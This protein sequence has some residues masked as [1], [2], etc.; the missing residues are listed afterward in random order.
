MRVRE[1]TGGDRSPH[2]AELEDMGGEAEKDFHSAVVSLFNRVY[3]PHRS[4]LA[5][6]RLAM[7]FTGKTSY[8][9]EHVEK[10]LADPAFGS[11]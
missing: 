4:G 8:G 6:T 11:S 10:A 9:E 7:T 2:A 3:Y 1:E 5:S